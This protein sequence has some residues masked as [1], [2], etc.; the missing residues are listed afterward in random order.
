[1][2]PQAA[3]AALSGASIAPFGDSFINLSD[4]KGSEE[5][6]EGMMNRE[7]MQNRGRMYRTLLYS[8]V[9]ISCPA[10]MWKTTWVHVMSRQ[11]AAVLRGASTAPFGYYM[12]QQL[13]H[14]QH[15]RKK[16]L[17]SC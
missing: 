1:M 9:T 13:Y 7:G 2:S 5:E 16:D 6:G 10:P 17:G 4:S 11:A 14:V 15:S 8:S 12:L 3:A